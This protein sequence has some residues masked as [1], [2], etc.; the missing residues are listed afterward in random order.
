MFPDGHPVEY[1]GSQVSGDNNPDNHHEGFGFQRISVILDHVKEDAVLAQQPN[2]V[3][4]H[5]GTN[6]NDFATAEEPYDQAPTRLEALLDHV[7]CHD[8]Y[9]VVL[10]AKLIENKYNGSQTALFNSAVPDIVKSRYSQGYKVALVD[11]TPVQGGE[12]ADLLHPSDAGYK[13][14]AEI[15]YDAILDIPYMWWEPLR[16]VISPQSYSNDT[17]VVPSA[18]DSTRSVQQSMVE[19]G[20]AL[21][22]TIFL[23]ADEDNVASTLE[24]SGGRSQPDIPSVLS[25]LVSNARH[26]W[27]DS[28]ADLSHRCSCW[29]GG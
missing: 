12:L 27:N 13:H 4:I 16:S 11:M 8:P 26:L 5:A 24:S 20:D 23:S 9:A 1:I 28:H 18:G 3:L 6:D 2:L 25:V 10:L 14:M 7:L 17:C 15:W 21:S 19:V 29:P 22:K